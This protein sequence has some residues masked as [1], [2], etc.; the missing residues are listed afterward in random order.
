MRRGSRDQ[1]LS[2][3]GAVLL[4][5]VMRSS[6]KIKKPSR[7]EVINARR[8]SGWNDRVTNDA[9]IPVD[10]G[11]PRTQ[12]RQ[13]NNNSKKLAED[14]AAKGK[15]ASKWMDEVLKSSFD[16]VP[17][18]L[19]PSL[20]DKAGR[21]IQARE[22]AEEIDIIQKIIVRENLLSEL[23]RLL[24]NHNGIHGVVGE[25]HELVKAIRFQ[26]VD[27]VEDIEA[28]QMMQMTRRPFLYRGDN[29]LTK[30]SQDMAHLDNYSDIAESFAF[31]FTGNP[32]AYPPDVGSRNTASFASSSSGNKFDTFEK[33]GIY[34][35]GS[36]VDGV[37]IIRLKN[38]EKTIQRNAE[39][40][41]AHAYEKPRSRQTRRAEEVS[42]RNN[43]DRSLDIGEAGMSMISTGEGLN[44]K[45]RGV[46]GNV[47][48]MSGNSAS[49]VSL[50]TSQR[51]KGEKQSMGNLNTAQSKN[52][53]KKF[54][55]IR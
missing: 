40:E 19:T 34:D 50:N 18:K 8:E 48:R 37:D 20:R 51:K 45:R 33:S 6:S 11:G 5:K 16:N 43:F 2:S 53:K 30:I 7:T 10:K 24:D 25:V 1:I 39:Y 17:L 12:M 21:E 13:F 14:N 27:I 41:I 9:K 28:W 29:Y 31:K 47:N 55:S 36:S 42:D 44:F 26:T 23:N 4:H 15:A 22:T 3:L 49:V 32:L 54:S 52:W 38:A 46:T 35:A